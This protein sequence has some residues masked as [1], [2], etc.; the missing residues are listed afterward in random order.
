VVDGVPGEAGAAWRLI[1]SKIACRPPATHPSAVTYYT[2]VEAC[3]PYVK[4]AP[5]TTPEVRLVRD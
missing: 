3:Y 4:P 2:F 1:S 5:D